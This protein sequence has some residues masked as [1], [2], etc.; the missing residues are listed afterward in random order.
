MSKWTNFRDSLLGKVT[1]IIWSGGPLD[2]F[3]TLLSLIVLALTKA[4][5][6]PE[7]DVTDGLS[8][9]ELLLIWGALD[10]KLKDYKIRK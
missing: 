6:I 7:I 1:G 4:G 5:V 10:A 9:D 3:K 2:N 8:V